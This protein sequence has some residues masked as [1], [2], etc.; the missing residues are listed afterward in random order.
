MRSAGIW[1][2]HC[3]VQKWYSLG[4]LVP[5]GLFHPHCDPSPLSPPPLSDSALQSPNHCQCLWTP[6]ISACWLVNEQSCLTHKTRC[7]AKSSFDVSQHF[8]RPTSRS[9]RTLAGRR[10][11]L[12]MEAGGRNRESQRSGAQG[13]FLVKA[14]ALGPDLPE[15][16]ALKWGWLDP[17]RGQYPWP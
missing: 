1:L 8:Q 7:G 12:L 17:S 3:M 9:S 13:W 5:R 2:K 15:C 10:V 6:S 4:K 16:C 14:M 11:S